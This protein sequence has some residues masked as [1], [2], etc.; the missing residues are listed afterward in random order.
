M[1]DS[2]DLGNDM[3]RGIMIMERESPQRFQHAVGPVTTHGALIANSPIVS[4][5]PFLTE[6]EAQNEKKHRWAEK[7]PV[8]DHG[9]HAEYTVVFN[10]LAG[11]TSDEMAGHFLLAGP[12]PQARWEQ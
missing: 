3:Q 2:R 6:E 8:V 12:G 1:Q 9:M 10:P 11:G 7:Q 5:G 4:S